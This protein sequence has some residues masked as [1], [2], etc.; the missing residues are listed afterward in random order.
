[1]LKVKE[2]AIATCRKHW[3]AFLIPGLVAFLF[4]IFGIIGLLSGIPGMAVAMFAVVLI[5]ALYIFISYKC[6]YIALTETRLVGKIGFI[7]SKELSTPLSKVQTIGVE[8]GLLGKIFRYHTIVIA[9]AG[10]DETEFVFNHMAGAKQF[11]SKVQ[12]QL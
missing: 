4:L 11:V 2:K 1:M 8:N 9:N 10:T 6:D 7:R 5:C 3:T 12:H